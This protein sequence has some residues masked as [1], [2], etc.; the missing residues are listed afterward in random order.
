MRSSVLYKYKNNCLPLLKT[1]VFQGFS[2]AMSMTRY[3]NWPVHRQGHETMCLGPIPACKKSKCHHP[4]TQILSQIP[5]GG[6]GNRGQMPHICP[7]SPPP[8]IGPNIDRCINEYSS[9]IAITLNL[10][11]SLFNLGW[12]KGW[13]ECSM[14][15]LW[16]KL[17]STIKLSK[18]SLFNCLLV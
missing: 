6:G 14:L 11:W 8:P 17:A 1:A 7:G 13:L 10:Y 12:L 2:C 5:E 15:W 18:K 9:S 16:T 4:G 3:F